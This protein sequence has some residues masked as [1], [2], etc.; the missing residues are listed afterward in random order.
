MLRDHAYLEAVAKRVG[1]SFYVFE[2]SRFRS[3]Y[4]NLLCLLREHW[5]C[6]DVAYAMKANYMPAIVTQLAE[7]GGSAEVVSRFEYDVARQG[8]PGDRIIFNGPI[9]READLRRAF[10]SGSLVNIDSFAEIDALRHLSSDFERLPI[11]IRLCFASPYLESRFGFEVETGELNGALR[12]LEEIGN[13]DVV[14][15]HCHASCRKRGVDDPVDRIQKL[16]EVAAELLSHQPIA[17]LNIGGGLLGEMPDAL[18]SQFPFPV[19]SME[20]YATA[21]GEAMRRCSPR[22]S[23]RLV[24]EPGVSMVANTMSLVARVVEVRLRRQGWQALLD[25]NINSVNPTRSATQ[26]VLYAVRALAERAESSCRYRL[27]GNT[28]M[29]HDVISK[30]FPGPLAEGD[31][32]VIPNRGA[33]SLNYTPPFIV[34]PPAVVDQRGRVLKQPDD[35]DSL[36]ASYRQLSSSCLQGYS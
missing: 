28:C 11:G 32:I 20:D 19:P 13:V 14:A 26:P 27:V 35:T 7:L 31:F 6:S 25:T 36:L 15:L 12:L 2:T 34:P 23:L 30:S 29:E 21:I 17:T 10:R 3:N 1:G 8:L 22:P 18:A 16:C 24:I 5:P 9:K 33:Y 4:Q